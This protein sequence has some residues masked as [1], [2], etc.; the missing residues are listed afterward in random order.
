MRTARRGRGTRHDD[1]R[2]SDTRND[3]QRDL[4]AQHGSRRIEAIH[5]TVHAQP[6]LFG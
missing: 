1:T 5:L 3:D 2:N 6:H 4:A